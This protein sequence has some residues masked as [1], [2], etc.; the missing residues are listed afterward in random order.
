MARARLVLVACVVT[1]A[2]VPASASARTDFSRQAYSINPAGET[3][4]L[5]P[6][7]NSTDQ[8]RLYDALTPRFGSVSA[9]DLRRY[10]KSERFGVQGR[11]KRTERTGRP[12]LR[13]QRDRFNVPHVFGRTRADVM[14]GSG[15]V[16]AED[17]GLLMQFGRG[18]ARIA[19][20]DVPGIDAFRLVITA[21][22][23]IPT[24]AADNF[25]ARQAGVLSRSRKGRQVLRDVDVWL[26][27]IN[28]YQRKNIPA[29]SRPKPWTRVDAFSGFAFIG[30]IFGNG[31]GD[32]VRNSQL[33]SSLQSS[34]GAG[35]GLGVFRDLREV[36]DPEAPTTISKRFSYEG[37]PTGPTPGSP[38]ADPDTFSASALA[39]ARTAA[40]AQR[41]ASNFLLV[42]ARRSTT[43]HPLAVMGPQLGYYYPGLF[44]EVDLHGG[45]IDVRGGAP[46]V[47]P[48]VLIGRGKDF[49]WSLTS[50]S[51]DNTDQFLEQLCNPDG[52]PATRAS[53]HYMYKGQ[54]RA[55]TTFDAGLLK[56]SGGAPD[57]ELVFHETVHGPV[58]GTVTVGGRP[59]AI[60]KERA[61]RGREPAGLLAMADL[62][63]NQVTGPKSFFAAVSQFETTF[64]WPYL[65]NRNV[66]YF[67]SGRLP[68]RAP[69]VDPS[70]PTLGTGQYDWRG[71]LKPS[72]HPQAIVS[73]SGLLLNWNGKPAPGWGSADNQWDRGSVHRVQLFRG[74]KRRNRLQDVASIMNRAATQDLRAVAVWPAIRRVLNT[75]P[76]PDA[77][78]AQAAALID[79]WLARGASRLDRNLDGKVDDPGAAVMDA[80][81]VPMAQAALRPVLGSLADV[82]GRF[83]TLHG[84]DDSP[85][86]RNGSAFGG[87]WYEYLDKD[88][89]TLLGDRVSGRFSRSY[90]GN[91]NRDACRDAL[92]AALEGASDGL[93]ASQGIDPNQWRA[94]ATAER[95][96]FLP[97]LIPQTMRWTNRPVFQQAIEFGSHR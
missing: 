75:G 24:R 89:R 54:C 81:F 97:S 26:A 8:A 32:E 6:D 86:G 28:A 43:G 48:Y 66:A 83:A 55:M 46:P 64:N 69:G 18:P 67:S 82:G 29:A 37:V 50:A 14:F 34:L 41:Q 45:G 1:V 74:F 42:G 9:T 16:M 44:A 63:T 79:A 96:K 10:F 4:G 62:N 30:S 92:W 12:G 59:F 70:L 53:D 78:T 33:L 40:S 68:I 73:P 20:L 76:A 5:P 91:G 49:A 56:G 13:I 47:S 3:G 38:I 17:R 61:T 71:F 23:F 90:C 7:A 84:P 35:P 15:W 27:G 22:T 21:Q 57:R 52:S 25:V 58:S 88:L 95:I 77:R 31:G 72:A 19:A 65:D 94:D 51:N 11:V 60:S 85:A 87:G 2:A 93:A 80:A 36:N 39:A